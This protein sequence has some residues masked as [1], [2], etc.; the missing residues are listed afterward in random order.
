MSPSQPMYLEW[1]GISNAGRAGVNVM[2]DIVRSGSLI[3]R[4]HVQ[5]P[6]LAWKP[7]TSPSKHLQTIW[8]VTDGHH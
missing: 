4:H 6:H 3:C 7:P 1:A 5:Q 8:K 2:T